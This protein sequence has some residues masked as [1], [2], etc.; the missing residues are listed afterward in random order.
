MRFKTLIFGLMIPILGFGQ[1]FK[2]EQQE[3]SNTDNTPAPC[4][5]IPH[6]RQILWNETEFYAFFH[7]GMNTFTGKEWGNGDESESIYAPKGMPD[8]EQWI[9][10]V[11]AAGMKGGIA[12]VKHHDGFCLWP[13]ATTTHNM[14][15]AGSEY[16][17]NA[18]IP[19]LYAEASRKH[20]M[21]YGFYISPWDRNSGL[22][23]TDSYVTEV[24]LKQCEELAEYGDDQFEMWFDGA[25]G[26]DGY[27]GG[28]YGTRSV[29]ADIYYDV[30]NLRARVHKIAPN[31]VLWGVGGEARWIGNE[32]GYAGETNW[33]MTDYGGSGVR[34]EGDIKGWFW[35]PGESD[36]KATSAGW[37]WHQ[38]ESMKSAE[39]LFQ[40]YL[41]TVGRNAT[42]I[43]NC[44]PN[45][46]GVLPANTVNELK[47][48]G[49]MLHERLAVPVY[50]LDD[51]TAA[52]DYAKSA[53]IE[54]SETRTGGKYEVTNLTD[55]DKDTYWGT[56]DDNLSATITL[57]WDNP[58]TIRYLVMQ[59]PIALGQRIK[60]FKIEYTA[61]GTTW[62]ELCPVMQTTTVGYKRIIPLNGKT[63]E[64][65]GNGY[66]AL[67]LRIS[68]LDSRACPLLSNLN[69]F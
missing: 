64:S 29:D 9:T 20:D 22:Y 69:V 31:C 2:L 43:L 4:H 7:Y 52:V 19:Q 66:K 60:D 44:P 3:L 10:A 28:S 36:A 54:V 61:D 16:G 14:T 32:S 8:P 58:Q 39:R 63:A 53:Q 68:I 59:E 11:K 45:Q 67:K 33:A 41:E 15:K 34:E 38:G 24:F 18:N 46:Y 27:Y 30:P 49:E 6:K 42:L 23:G 5:P 65:Y 13:T 12:V 37:F 25:N 57:S 51:N 26:G 62:T 40:M 55:G 56:N 35:H 47:K 21:K 50:G 1:E 48:L 17:R